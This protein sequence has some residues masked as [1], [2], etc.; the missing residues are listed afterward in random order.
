VN[1]VYLDHAATTPMRPEV[2]AAM[3]PYL[4]ERFGNPSSTHRWGRQAR[5]ALEEA[6][7]RVAA[8]IGAG[9]REVVFTSG[10]TEADNMAVLGRWRSA[11]RTDRTGDS[12]AA[13]SRGA[14]VCSAVEH[15]AV[16]AAAQCA[17]EEG[18][19]LIVLASDEDGRVDLG[20]LD[21]ALESLPCIVSV[22]WANN[23]VGTIQPVA[24]IAA[25][26][27]SRGVVFH[28]DAVQAF[29]K[30]PVSVDAVA[31]DLL[32]LSG[33]KIGGP[34]G[35]GALYVRE[36][37][38]VLPLAHGGGQERQLRPG[39]ENVAAAVGLAAAA[40]LAAEEHAR[41]AARMAGLRDR[42]ESG[43]RARIPELIVNAGRADRLP[44]ILN[45]TVPGADQEELLIGLDLEGVAASGGSA[46]QS[47]TIKP[48]HVLAAMGAARAGSANVRLSVGWTTTVEEIDFA[49]DAFGR[50]VEQLR[51]EAGF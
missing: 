7:E 25:R 8:A 22:M 40:Q 45:V 6:R 10:G 16:G 31:C 48:S 2:R 3:G 32:S 26:C 50:V 21:E 29:G 15:K 49:L 41:H 38:A 42:L 35:I 14:V 36:A 44:N 30:V 13:G 28:T 23:E 33:H 19:A 9:R 39:T 24:E 46:C 47:G 11:C 18:A 17:A 5:N 37:T 4:D 1:S 34:K 43:L 20:A 51:A 27:R 12:V